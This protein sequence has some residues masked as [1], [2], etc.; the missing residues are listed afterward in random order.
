MESHK[1]TMFDSVKDPRIEGRCSH[2]L[3]SILFIA[4][5]TLISNGEDCIDMEE[6]GK[7]NLAWLTNYIDL[8]NGIP[9]HDTFNRV[10][11]KLS[12]KELGDILSNNGKDLIKQIA[13][14]HIAIDGKRIKGVS[15]KSRGNRGLYILN[16]WISES[17]ICIGQKRIEDKT[18]E[19]SEIP[20]LLESLDIQ[21]SIV[22]IDAIGCQKGIC[23]QIITQG[24]DYLLSVK[25]NQKSLHQEI[26]EIFKYSEVKQKDIEHQKDHGREESRECL[27]LDAASHLSPDMQKKWPTVNKII[28]I[29]GVR[30]LD[31]KKTESI[32]YYISSNTDKTAKQFNKLIRSHWSIENHLHWH[33]DVT[34]NED[35]CRM[36]TGHA[37]E[38]MNI[39]RKLALTKIRNQ[40]DKKSLKK[41][42]YR[43]SLDNNYLAQLLLN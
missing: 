4:T 24:A 5:C 32:R 6:Y 26:Q 34:F 19:I 29:K 33:L 43:A 30:I 21:S 8:P 22:S 41:R 20:V 13:E 40:Q 37:P 25:G 2:K 16:A 3:S 9:T 14:K 7:A 31:N 10:L 11:Q 28:Q 27:V 36:R 38:N 18:N 12:P 35:D 39:L 42:R 1:I 15:P 17:N 23:N